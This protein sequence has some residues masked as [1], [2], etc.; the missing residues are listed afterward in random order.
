MSPLCLWY[1]ND[2]TSDTQS[3]TILIVYVAIVYFVIVCNEE[4]TQLTQG[5]IIGLIEDQLVKQSCLHALTTIAVN[6]SNP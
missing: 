2:V 4:G 3:H 1:F 6:V 5:Q